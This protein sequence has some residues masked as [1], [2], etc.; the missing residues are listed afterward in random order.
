MSDLK[1][2]RTALN[3]DLTPG[4]IAAIKPIADR[5]AKE[6]VVVKVA[7]GSVESEFQTLGLNMS[8]A[9]K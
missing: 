8:A 2:I 4:G 9:G 1:D 5:V 6:T 7:A 3:S